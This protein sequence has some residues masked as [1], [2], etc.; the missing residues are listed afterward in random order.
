MHFLFNPRKAAQAAA[1]LVKL[2]DGRMSMFALI[3]ILYLADRKSLAQRGR[4]IT[5]DEMVS[6]PHG[7][8]LSRI[9]DNIKCGPDDKQAQPWNEYLTEREDN[10]ISLRDENPPTDELSEYERGVLKETLAQYGHFGFQELRAI[11]H[12]LP[13]Y[14]DPKGS[15]RPIDPT[16]ILREEGWSDEEIQDA[17][18]SAREE[19]FLRKISA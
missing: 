16:I 12:G 13:E 6:M 4:S 1:Y 2:S 7:P 17:L 9:Y 19:A 10:T 14:Q 3:K 8:V 11:T 18:M 5:G 15:S